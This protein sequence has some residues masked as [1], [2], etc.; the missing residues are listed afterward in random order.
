MLAVVGIIACC[1][2][3]A[4]KGIDTSMAIAAIVASVAASRGYEKAKTGG[5]DGPRRE[6]PSDS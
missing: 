1:I 3:G 5:G 2:I 4:K 6:T